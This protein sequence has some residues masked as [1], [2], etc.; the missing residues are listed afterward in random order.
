MPEDIASA[1][2]QC[3]HQGRDGG[4]EQHIFLEVD[5]IESWQWPER[6]AIWNSDV[7]LCL[8]MLDVQGLYT[9]LH[10]HARGMAVLILTA[11]PG[12]LRW[13]ERNGDPRKRRDIDGIG[14]GEVDNAG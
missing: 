5:E 2:A 13:R 6:A 9:K 4:D 11:K 12:D 3:G 10:L 8:T 1:C 7:P 14:A